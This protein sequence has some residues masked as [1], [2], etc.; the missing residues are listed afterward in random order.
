[1]SQIIYS[2][3]GFALAIAVLVVVHEFGHYWV[4]RRLGVKV[5]RFSVGFGRVLWSRRAGPDQTEYALAALPL[6]GYVKML[7]ENE[8]EVPAAERH[9]AF[10]RQAVWKRGA[11]VFAGPFFNFLFAIAAYWVVLM[12]GVPGLKPVVGEVVP[13]SP[14]AQAG[15]HRGDV[16]LRLNGHRVLSWDQH[17][18]LLLQKAVEHEA[19]NIEVRNRAGA[20]RVRTLNLDTITARAVSD[21]SFER[22][23]GLLGYVP[24]VR[25]VIGE[26]I[27]GGPAARAGLLAGDQVLSVDGMAVPTWEDLVRE[28]GQNPERTLALEVRRG[29]QILTVNVTPKATEE[30]GNTVG[31]IGA[32]VK[33]P[34][35][36]PDLRVTVRLGPVA[37]FRGAVENT[38]A[39]SALTVE[40]LYKMI[41][42]KVSAK[43]ISGP[44]T[45]AQYAGYSVQ[46]GVGTFL[47]FLAFV[48]VSLGVLNLLPVPVLDGGHL[49][50]YVMEAVKGGP[51]SEQVVGWGQRVGIVLLMSLVLL[52]FYNDFVRILQ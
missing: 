44:I 41:Q 36:P 9:R 1:M 6:G 46:M 11:I 26:I 21:G 12:I 29:H 47:T 7:D 39:M 32:A 50:F 35:I 14:A 30:G 5:L 52:A 43:N 17:R 34:E 28:I 24:K 23:V 40:M 45:I 27:K 15:F 13:G 31:K 10:N 42:L 33:L 49:L 51:V 8:G 19:V 25:P 4:A 3:V 18:L 37:A 20:V 22:T 48:S 2:I 38:W 16:L